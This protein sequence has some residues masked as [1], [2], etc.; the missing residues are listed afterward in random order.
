[1]AVPEASGGWGAT[2]LDLALVAEQVGRFLAPA[3]IIE[4]Q[5]AVR[6]LAHLSASVPV[7]AEA[8][9]AAIGGESIL[10]LALHPGSGGQARLVPAGLVADQVIV[11]VGDRLLLVAP[12][13][14]RDP[15][16]NLGSMPLAD[17]SVD[18]AFELAAGIDAVDA[19]E[20]AIDEWCTLVANALIGVAARGLEIGVD[21][22]K[23]RKAFDVPIGSFQAISH[24]LADSATAVDGARLLAW[25]A[26]WAWDE[27]PDRAPELGNLAFAFA[28]ETARDAT[29]RSL[30][31]HGG[32]GFMMESDIQLFWRRA[33]AWANVFGD[34]AMAYGRAADRRYGPTA[35]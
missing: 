24:R 8:L 2:M 5:V 21:Y 26:A 10:T 22:V 1:M 25:E 13:A 11:R 15:I 32:Y 31:F 20:T 6:L 4:S 7:A 12:P 16:Q 14:G 17:L 33:R 9:R 18:G 27:A 23:E 30:H 28:A 29:Y 3:P 34:A 19:Y 35:S